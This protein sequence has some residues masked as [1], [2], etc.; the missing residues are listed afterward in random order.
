MAVG[1]DSYST[2]G[3]KYPCNKF[4]SPRV[5]GIGLFISPQGSC[6]AKIAQLLLRAEEVLARQCDGASRGRRTQECTNQ[7]QRPKAS[8][9][10]SH[11]VGD[12]SQCAHL[13]SEEPEAPRG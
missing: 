3:L 12:R 13:T 1:K 11:L 8:C 10:S 6:L 9:P 5:I 7:A 2:W 4:Q